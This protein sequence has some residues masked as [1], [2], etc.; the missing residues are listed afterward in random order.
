MTPKPT[1]RQAVKGIKEELKQRL[2][3]LYKDNKARKPN[4]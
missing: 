4:F 2:D 3:G 1:L